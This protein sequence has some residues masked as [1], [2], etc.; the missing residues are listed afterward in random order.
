[1]HVRCR[2]CGCQQRTTVIP[3]YL[4]DE[5]IFQNRERK[6]DHRLSILLFLPLL[7]SFCCF[8]LGPRR[9]IGIRLGAQANRQDG[10]GRAEGKVPWPL[11]GLPA[12]AG[13]WC[14]RGL[15]EEQAPRLVLSGT[16][17][18]LRRGRSEPWLCSRGHGSTGELSKKRFG[19]A[20][21]GG[22]GGMLARAGRMKLMGCGN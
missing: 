3:C 10:R 20:S 19:E 5:V 13:A 9:Q 11:P 1:M 4:H 14:R 18:A 21:G 15:G 6:R 8:L 7:S 22:H 17:E 12:S 2:P 16:P